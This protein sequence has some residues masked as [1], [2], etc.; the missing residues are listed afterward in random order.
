MTDAF[1]E[2]RQE[3]EDLRQQVARWERR[4]TLLERR[5]AFV[6]AVSEIVDGSDYP[7]A[8]GGPERSSEDA[9]RVIGALFSDMVRKLEAN[10]DKAHWSTVSQRYLLSRL[11]DELAELHVA[12]MN[13]KPED[14][15]AEAADLAN[16]AMMIHDNAG[17]T[18]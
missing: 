6:R 9:A 1:P 2:L 18:G 13:G 8:S 4:V 5:F 11:Y 10:K 7:V 15:R 3:N 17:R 12:L 16:L 14:V